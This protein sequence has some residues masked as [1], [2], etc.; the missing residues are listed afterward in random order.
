MFDN[1]LFVLIER[2]SLILV[3]VLLVNILSIVRTIIVDELLLLHK[4]FLIVNLLSSKRLDH[5]LLR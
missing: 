4:T 1:V 3:S 2:T 5:F